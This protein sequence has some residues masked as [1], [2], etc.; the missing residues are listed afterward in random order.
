MIGSSV[1]RKSR[2]AA[3]RL[4]L[5]YPQSRVVPYALSGY[6]WANTDVSASA[7]P[8]GTAWMGSPSRLSAAL[9]A[10]TGAATW[11]RE[12]ARAPQ[13]WAGVSPLNFYGSSNLTSGPAQG[14][15]RFGDVRLAAIPL[16]SGGELAEAN[17]PY[18]TSGGGGNVTL[19][20]V[21]DFAIG[22]T[23]DLY[24]VLR[25]EAN[26]TPGTASV[27]ALPG[28]GAAVDVSLRAGL[29]YSVEV[30]SPT[31]SFLVHDLTISPS[32]RAG[33]GAAKPAKA[34]ALL[35]EPA[36]AWSDRTPGPD[37]DGDGR[38]GP[39]FHGFAG[40]PGAE[41][42][43]WLMGVDL[44]PDAPAAAGADTW[45]AGRSTGDPHHTPDAP[46]W[47]PGREYQS[48]DSGHPP[49]PLPVLCEV[50]KSETI[51]PTCPAHQGVKLRRP[52]T[53]HI[54]FDTIYQ[55]TNTT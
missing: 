23:Y 27:L 35:A 8:D 43:G 4:A 36:S 18:P 32:G 52:G 11:Q 44:R 14:A 31:G 49:V 12:L 51:P 46:A 13:T 21:Y 40:D 17:Y 42:I 20:T 34:A 1:A 39:G 37:P 3:R 28:V 54:V 50:G 26:D 2:S 9:D 24:S 19:S 45:A 47:A 6:S 22:T 7:V 10:V 30:D 16:G 48:S 38:P 33:G 5:E 29:R 15:P 53:I 41:P 55:Q 25:H